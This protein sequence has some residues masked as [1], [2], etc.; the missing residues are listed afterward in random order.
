[1]GK[2]FN[3]LKEEVINDLREFYWPTWD[4]SPQGEKLAQDTEK[5][6]NLP[7]GSSEY[8]KLKSHLIKIIGR[9]GIEEYS[10]GKEGQGMI[11]RKIFDD[12]TYLLSSL[13]EEINPI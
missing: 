10:R 8:Y 4:P 12:L 7:V 2:Q 6:F 5:L 13:E 9:N 3:D 11:T 1:M